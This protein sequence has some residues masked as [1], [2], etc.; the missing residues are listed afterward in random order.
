MECKVDHVV[1]APPLSR[2]LI[3]TLWNVKKSWRYVISSESSVL[4]ETLWNVKCRKS[5]LNNPFQHV[6]I[7]TL[8]NVKLFTVEQYSY[9][10]SVLIETLWNVK[11]VPSTFPSCDELSINRNIVECKG[12]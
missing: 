10:A 4:I 1:N 7:E 8:W 2:V 12:V 11:S 9:E 6:L 5:Y 3:E